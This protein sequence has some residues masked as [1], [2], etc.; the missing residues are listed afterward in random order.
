[1]KIFTLP[2][3][4][5]GLLEA[6]IVEWFC[7]EGDTVSE[8]QPLLSVE[9]AKAIVDIPSP[10]SGTIH[11]VFAQT[12]ELLHTQDPLVEFDHQDSHSVVGS[13]PGQ[14]QQVK[15]SAETASSTH[16]GVKATPAVRALASRLD[17][18]L[19]V[20]TPSGP[21]GAIKAADVE[22]VSKIFQQVGVLKPLKGVRRAMSKAMSQ[23]HSEVVSVT[24]N[25]DADISGWGEDDDFTVRLA[26][27]IIA[28]CHAVPQLN[29]WY[30]SHSIGSRQ[31]P[32]VHLG[33][34]V[35]TADGLFVPVINHADGLDGE[36]LRAK[37]DET[38]KEVVERKISADKLRGNTITL[39]NFGPLGG[40]Y[41]NP[42]IIPPTVAI[43]GAG[44]SYPLPALIS[45]QGD[46]DVWLNKTYLPLSLSF[47]HRCIT[48]GEA[49]R[50]LQAMIKALV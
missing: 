22:R 8:D 27:A 23:S 17:I 5:E 18:D 41:A 10:C 20:V 12:G 33:L 19:N 13:L 47:D 32:Q 28:A 7:K 46:S 16:V 35:D 21:D 26:Q 3:L 43:V 6:E 37:I 11:K 25:D 24:L 2:D 44:R 39:S 9:T 45:R 34:A 4:G 1:M 49:A 48:G 14:Q 30:D 40:R 31:I 15:E 50:F 36:A 38:I 42:V 29:A